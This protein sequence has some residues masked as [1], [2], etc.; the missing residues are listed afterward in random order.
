MVSRIVLML[1]ST[2]CMIEVHVNCFN[3]IQFSFIYMELFQSNSHNIISVRRNPLLFIKIRCIC[4]L[5]KNKCRILITH[6]LQHLR[7]ADQI[8]VLKEVCPPLCWFK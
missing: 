4:G 1:D 6:Q 8:L 3:S 5:L 2:H 7:T